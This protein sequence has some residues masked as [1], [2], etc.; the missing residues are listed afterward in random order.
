MKVLI[1]TDNYYT[2]T[3][4]V[5]TS[6]NNLYSELIKR[7]HEVRILTFSK[8]VHK[9]IEGDVYY[10]RSLP[11]EFIYPG[12][13]SPYS[14]SPETIKDIVK[15]KPDIIHSQCE[16][17]SYA[18]AL[19][20]HKKCKCPIVHTYHTLYEDYLTYLFP[21]K[22]FSA[23]FLK[24]FMKR[25]LRKAATIIA[26]TNKVKSVLSGYGISANID[27]IPSGINLSQHKNR[28]SAEERR[29]IRNKYS[30]SDSDV[31]MMNLGRLGGEKNLDEVITYFASASKDYPQLKLMLVG[32]GP[33]KESLEALSRK[34]GISN[35]VIFTGMVKPDEVQKYYQCGDIFTS[36][37]TSET[38][39]LTYIEA[40]ANGLPLLC[41][42]D[43]VLEELVINGKNGY[44]YSTKEEY[45]NSLGL[46]VEDKIWRENASKESLRISSS[47]DKEFFGEKIIECYKKVLNKIV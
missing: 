1:T 3:N 8:D 11:L 19:K 18:F 45:L 39:G 28:I 12:V 42:M 6:I 14:V 37:S 7:G 15:R 35:R 21:E 25:R 16:F 36:A 32:G 41:R 9:H 17:F 29:A 44:T 31:V 47:Y 24:R 2:K 5:V 43:P 10:L 23:R 4:G 13:R 30:I 27:V 26:P 22:N 20:V 33:A 40:T 38:Q 34:L 46:M